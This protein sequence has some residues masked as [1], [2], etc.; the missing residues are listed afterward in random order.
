MNK[1]QSLLANKHTSGAAV[2]YA[3]ASIVGHIA[4]TWFPAYSHQIAVTVEYVKEGCFIWMGA[5]ATDSSQLGQ[6]KKDVQDIKTGNTDQFPKPPEQTP[7]Q[8]NQ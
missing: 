7:K 6:V 3:L 8:T 2:V 4:G 5:A 1:L